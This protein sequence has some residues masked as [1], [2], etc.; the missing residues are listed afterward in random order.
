MLLNHQYIALRPQLV[1]RHHL[2][3]TLA[4]IYSALIDRYFSSRRH[5]QK[6]YD[7]NRQAYF[8]N[9]SLPSMAA[10]WVISVS[11]VQRAYDRLEKLGLLVKRHRLNASDCLFLPELEGWLYR[12]TFNLT[13]PAISICPTKHLTLTH[14]F[15]PTLKT[16][17][18]PDPEPQSVTTT[19]SPQPMTV[20]P[21]K[22]DSAT[23]TALVNRLEFTNLTRSLTTH[24]GIPA[25]TAQLM[26]SLS[27][28]RHATLHEMARV[29]YQ[30]KAAVAQTAQRHLGA[31][32][33]AATRFETNPTLANTLHQAVA[34]IIPAA[35]RKNR[36]HWQGF[37]YVAFVQFFE[38]AANAWL[39]TTAHKPPRCGSRVTP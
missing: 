10:D 15:K 19:C 12:G 28:Q 24:G 30:A 25:A 26:A 11:T 32:G 37:A 18:T 36:Q 35:Y 1:A 6:F 22:P 7:A 3:P 34:R 33:L 4:V 2:N 39:R 31:V 9:Y 13:R 16:T 5:G 21:D 20:Q 23:T 27:Y 17:N 8:V 29:I 38:E 14:S